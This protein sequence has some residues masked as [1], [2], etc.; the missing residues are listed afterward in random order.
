M[1][2]FTPAAVAQTKQRPTP[3]PNVNELSE[4]EFQ[5]VVA[6]ARAKRHEFKE[7][8]GE[9]T[10][11]RHDPKLIEDMLHVRLGHDS[12]EQRYPCE[13]TYGQRESSSTKEDAPCVPGRV[14]NPVR[15]GYA[16]G[17][18]G[19]VAFLPDDYLVLHPSFN[20]EDRSKVHQFYVRRVRF[21]AQGQPH[22]IVALEPT[23]RSAADTEPKVSQED[24]VTR[25]ARLKALLDDVVSSVKVKDRQPS[26]AKTGKGLRPRKSGKSA[27]VVSDQEFMDS[28]A[29]FLDSFGSSNGSDGNPDKKK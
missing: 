6:E 18:G 14:L 7:R 11:R 16:V 28:L 10:V 9:A 1:E 3:P 23:A 25:E 26:A 15:G 21:N 27:P 5:R 2:H 20:P 8:V 4:D 13:L 24:M 17:L 29:D 19:M 22:I 12:L